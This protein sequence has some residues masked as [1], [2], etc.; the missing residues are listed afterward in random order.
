MA[1]R[2]VMDNLEQAIKKNKDK[3]ILATLK[4]TLRCLEEDEKA[5]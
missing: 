4:E 1:K 2:C 3:N 5:G